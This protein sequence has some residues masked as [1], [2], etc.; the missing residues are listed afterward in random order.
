MG[1]LGLPQRVS[2]QELLERRLNPSGPGMK[3]VRREAIEYLEYG[4]DNYWTGDKMIDQT[5]S[6]AIP[7]FKTHIRIAKHY[8]PLTMP[9]IT[10]L[11]PA[12]LRSPP[13]CI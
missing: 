12:M 4:K 1:I 3:V 7:T 2:D 5:I 9:Q 10:V 8:L 13:K 11:S 6:V